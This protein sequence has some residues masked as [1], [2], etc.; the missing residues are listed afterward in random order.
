MRRC[1]HFTGILHPKCDAGVLYADV[2][3]PPAAPGS[4]FQ[5]PCFSDAGTECALRKTPTLAE[6]TEEERKMN[7]GFEFTMAAIKLINAAVG[8]KRGVTGTIECP[9]CKGRL[10]YSVAGYNG[11]IHGKCAT[12]GCLS[13]MM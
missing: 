8:K 13:W 5:F 9:K 11:H 4:G 3:R 2:R 10:H 6:A 7:E 1:V 12:E